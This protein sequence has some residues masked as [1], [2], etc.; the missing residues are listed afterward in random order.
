MANG[1]TRVSIP[2]LEEAITTF[3]NKKVA[4]ENAYLKISN[5]VRELDTTWHGEASEKFKARF[6]ELYKNLQVTEERM[7]GAIAKLRTAVQTYQ[8]VED[9]NRAATEALDEGNVSYF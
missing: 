7:D 2:A 5:D 8:E 9:E 6:D 4:L 1:I 3:E